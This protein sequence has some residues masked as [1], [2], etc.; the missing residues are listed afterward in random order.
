MFPTAKMIT[1]IDSL[2][3]NKA[4]DTMTGTLSATKLV[5]TGNVTAGNGMYLPAT[6]QIAFSTNG[7]ER[8]RIDASGNVG[9][10][11]SAPQSIL[12]TQNLSAGI[13]THLQLSHQNAF[14]GGARISF[15]AANNT[16]E[17]N[18]I[19]NELTA[20][21]AA[22][23]NLKFFTFTAAGGLTQKMYIS[24]AG[25][26]GIGTSSDG[27]D[28][29]NNGIWL[30]GGIKTLQASR[31]ND[32]SINAAR[33]GTNGDVLTFLKAADTVGSVSVTTT[34]ATYNTSSDYRLKE[35]AAPITG[36]LN[37]VQL[38]NPV[39]YNWKSDGSEGEGFIAHELQEVVPYAVNGEK[40]GEQM[41]GVDYGKLSTLLTAAVKELA[42]KVELLEAQL[43]AK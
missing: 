30:R 17:I 31:N 6:N 34:A 1:D 29:T 42:N 24:G 9:I 33:T 3:V 39:T 13:N 32:P 4:G 8:M 11:T 12:H 26:V 7:A 25:N 18:R 36:A 43:E 5:P 15:F 10:G 37:R 19:E 23:G 27:Y 2:K 28:G 38:L 41:Q 35:N 22:S 21:A 40:D 14:G 20:D 16:T